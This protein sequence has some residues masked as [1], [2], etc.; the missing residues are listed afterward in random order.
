MACHVL[1]VKIFLA[2]FAGKFRWWLWHFACS[3][4]RYTREACSQIA[5]LPRSRKTGFPPTLP[6]PPAN[7]LGNRAPTG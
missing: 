4:Y 5:I 1:Q 6:Q 2:I 7:C 3:V